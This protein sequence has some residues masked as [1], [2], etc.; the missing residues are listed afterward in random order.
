M[1]KRYWNN[2]YNFKN[3]SLESIY[4]LKNDRWNSGLKEW[5]SIIR[6]H[7]QHIKITHFPVLTLALSLMFMY[8]DAKAIL[9]LKIITKNIH[10]VSHKISSWHFL[11]YS[12]SKTELRHARLQNFHASEVRL[13][14]KPMCRYIRVKETKSKIDS[15]ILF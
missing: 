2:E 13:A 14:P 4:F 9:S 7:I 12:L 6:I 5:D 10:H 15:C 11:T 3:Q 8:W 1:C